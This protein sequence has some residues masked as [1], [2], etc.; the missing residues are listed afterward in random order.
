MQS[1]VENLSSLASAIRRRREQ[2]GLTQDRLAALAGL[3]RATVNELENSLIVDL[4]FSKLARLLTLLDLTLSLNEAGPPAAT[5]AAIDIAT[6]TRSASTSYR[7]TLPPEEF[8]RALH[9]GEMPAPYRAHI[10]TMLDEAPV[11]V[12][13]SAVRG[14][15]RRAV[16]KQTWRHLA[17]WAKEL[18]CTR[19]IWV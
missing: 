1:L 3:S 15:F 2:L 5:R 16:P 11:P 6:A 12:I 9:T 18:K 13:V 17:K 8:V 4:G 10:A 7:T 14:A 19:P